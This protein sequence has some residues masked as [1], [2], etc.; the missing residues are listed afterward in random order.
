[1]ILRKIVEQANETRRIN[2]SSLQTLL[3]KMRLHDTGIIT[4]SKSREPETGRRITYK[5]KKQSNL[6]LL[7]ALRTKYRITKVRGG[8]LEGSKKVHENSFFVEDPND[9]GNLERDLRDLGETF[10]KNNPQDSVLFIPKGGKSA[11]L[12]GTNPF[13]PNAFP[14]HGESV[15]FNNLKLGTGGEFF[16]SIH[17]R[18]FV[19]EDRI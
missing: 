12:W 19:F 18:P 2:E 5:E 15:S 8:G 4:A 14:K 1:M 10:K 7:K 17:N 13:D 3:S 6:D 11:K 9:T 16:T